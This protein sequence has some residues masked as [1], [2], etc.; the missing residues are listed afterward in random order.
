MKTSLQN[1]HSTHNS[2]LRVHHGEA[3]CNTIWR[4]AF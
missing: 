1:D 4:V 2:M 3:K